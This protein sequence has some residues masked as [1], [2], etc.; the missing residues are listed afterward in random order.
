MA[1][2]TLDINQYFKSLTLNDKRRERLFVDMMNT[3]YK[4]PGE[5]IL[6]ASG[7]RNEAKKIYRL[8]NHLEE[9]SDHVLESI[10]MT[11]MTKAVAAAEKSERVLFIQDTTS[12]SYGHRNI[13]GMGYDCDSSQKGRNVHS[14]IAMTESGIAL[15]MIH[16]ETRTRE[17][18]KRVSNEKQGNRRQGKFPLDQYRSGRAKTGISSEC[19]Y[20]LPINM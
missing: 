16:Q 2:N 17:K 19:N 4:T 7:S 8:L 9:L 1:E 11:T 10:A 18:Q 15:G 13:D 20:G 14:C 6:N 12:I 3:L 5:S